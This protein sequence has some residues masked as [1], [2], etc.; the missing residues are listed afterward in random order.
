MSSFFTPNLQKN[1]GI[2]LL[3]YFVIP[4]SYL[5]KIEI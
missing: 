5:S 3:Y 2:P 1:E 4:S